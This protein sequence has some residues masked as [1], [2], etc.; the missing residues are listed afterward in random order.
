MPR[1]KT[2]K[3]YVGVA[4]RR[5]FVVECRKAGMTFDQIYEAAKAKFGDTLPPS[6][7][8]RTAHGDVMT[9]LSEIRKLTA[10]DAQAIYDLEVER[11]DALL[12]GLWAAAEGGDLQA[13]D[14]ALRVAERRAKLMGLDAPV[15]STTEQSGELTFVVRWD[16]GPI[17]PLAPSETGERDE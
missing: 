17:V 1:A 16:D 14:R 2:D 13:V 9:Y 11:L 4:E 15:R 3:L 12:H 5:R 7:S 6:Y 10:N 8:K